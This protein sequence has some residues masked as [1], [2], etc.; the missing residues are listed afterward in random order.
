MTTDPVSA[1][2]DAVYVAMPNSPTL[3]RIWREQA[4]GVDFPED[5]Y[6]ISFVTRVE[7]LRMAGELR[8]GPGKT[9]V[10]L[11]C[12]LGGPALLVAKH[13]GARLIG[14]DL[15][16]VAVATATTR[17]AGLGLGEQAEFRVGSFAET[18][19]ADGSVDAA[20]SEDA[21][22][23]APDKK[24]AMR[25]AARILRQ[26]GHFVFSVFE[27]DEE[28]VRGLPVLGTDPCG[29]YRPALEGAGFAVDAYEEA[30]GW[31]EP[32]TA[33]YR[34]LL[35]ARE[36]LVA[37]MGEAAVNALSGE[38]SMTLEIKPYRRRVLVVATKR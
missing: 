15:S 34:A 5:F 26:G 36:A 28:R 6:H 24:E 21:L 9:F 12:G 19:L 23:Y 8:G 38:L 32:M 30:P 7:L 11:G 10:D 2:Y 4:C 37:E 14:V 35:D 3:K 29:D 27:L 31:P 16:P 22:Q 17:A 13:T 33:A 20:M 18:G 1:G 25:E